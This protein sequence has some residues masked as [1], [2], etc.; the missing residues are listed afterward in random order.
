MSKLSVSSTSSFLTVNIA[1]FVIRQ[2]NQRC[3]Q[4]TGLDIQCQHCCYSYVD[5]F[6]VHSDLVKPSTIVPASTSAREST[7]SPVSRA[8]PFPVKRSNL[9]QHQ[10]QHRLFEVGFFL[11]PPLNISITTTTIICS[12]CMRSPFSPSKLSTT[13]SGMSTSASPILPPSP[14]LRRL[15]PPILGTFFHLFQKSQILGTDFQSM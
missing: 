1:S 8:A 13:F 3:E 12:T 10:H 7:L 11:E 4:G 9:L 14:P 2:K 6:A 5:I 15:L